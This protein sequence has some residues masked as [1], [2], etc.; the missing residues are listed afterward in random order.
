MEIPSYL[1]A[2][3]E[4]S[5]R[6]DSGTKSHIIESVIGGISGGE[7][8]IFLELQGVP[9]IVLF[10]PDSMTPTGGPFHPVLVDVNGRK[11]LCMSTVSYD[12]VIALA[13]YGK[14]RIISVTFS[15]GQPQK[16]EGILSPGQ[17]VATKEG[18]HFSAYDTSN[19]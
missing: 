5:I 11:C 19:A 10:D 6:R 13:G 2:G 14:G 8:A 18:M 12:E 16:P 3:N 9:G 15:R 4:I 1:C 7:K 17:S